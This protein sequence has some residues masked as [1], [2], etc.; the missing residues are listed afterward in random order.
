MGRV[1][2][3]CPKGCGKTMKKHTF[4]SRFRLAEFECVVCGEIYKSEELIQEWH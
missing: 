1:P 4:P 3:W 2:K